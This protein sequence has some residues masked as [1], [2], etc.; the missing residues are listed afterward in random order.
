MLAT[1]DHQS[2]RWF[3]DQPDQN[4]DY[5]VHFHYIVFKDGEDRKKD[6][7][8]ELQKLVESANNK[9]FQAAKKNKYSKGVGKNFKL[10]YTKKAN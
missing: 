2:T 3:D 6:S 5:S 1:T 4:K 7:N 10:D 9:F 8:G